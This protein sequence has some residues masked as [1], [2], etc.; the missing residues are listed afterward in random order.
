MGRRR[1]EKKGVLGVNA[2]YLRTPLP[3]TYPALASI[4]LKTAA[5]LAASS[6]PAAPVSTTPARSWTRRK[7]AD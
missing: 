6:V 1:A 5:W 7:A 2:P 4:L 3:L